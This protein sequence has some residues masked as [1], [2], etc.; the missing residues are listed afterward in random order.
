M[1]N[2]IA[3]YKHE[4]KLRLVRSLPA[5]IQDVDPAAVK[6]VIRKITESV[7]KNK[8]D[9]NEKQQIA[10]TLSSEILGHGPIDILLKDPLVTEIMINGHN[11]IYAERKGKLC[12]TDI[13]F[14]NDEQ[15]LSFIDK[16]LSSAGRRVTELEPYADAR[17]NDGSRVNV[18]RSPIS[19]IPIVTIRKFD[20]HTLNIQELIQ[21]DTLNSQIANFLQACVKERTNIIISGGTG[22][23]KTTL[24][25]TL[26]CFIPKDERVIIIENTRELHLE[27]PHVVSMECRPPSIDGKGEIALRQLVKNSLHMRPSRIILGEVRGDEALDVIQAMNTGQQGSLCTIHSNSCI[28]CLERLQVL[29]LLGNSNITSEVAMR[30]TIL[31][32]D[33]IIQMARLKNGSRKIMEIAEVVKNNEPIFS[34]RK[35]FV[36]KGGKMVYTGTPPS[37][38]ARLKEDGYPDPLFENSKK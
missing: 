32:V 7:V 10:E 11:Q 25:N 35:I 14:S 21:L 22:A 8:L 17:L 31:A 33:L 19:V 9:S 4:I 38:Y 26:G 23:G 28:D 12:L 34:L 37:F 13:K 20:F 2:Q 1:N 24:L 36:R 30:Q 3:N 27:H 16:I 6:K 29:T 5:N 18:V 15:L